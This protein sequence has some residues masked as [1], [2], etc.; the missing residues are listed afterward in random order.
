MRLRTLLIWLTVFSVQ[1][2][3]MENDCMLWEING[4]D[5][6]FSCKTSNFVTP[7]TL[8][9]NRGKEIAKCNFQQFNN[10]SIRSSQRE[11]SHTVSVE[12]QKKEVRFTI[13]EFRS[14]NVDGTWSCV[15]GNTKSQ[16]HVSKSKEIF[17]DTNVFMKGEIYTINHTKRVS[18][19][20]ST[21]RESRGK[22][23]E[24]LINKR[25]YVSIAFDPDKGKCTYKDRECH[26]DI[27]SCSSAGNVFN[28]TFSFD[29]ANTTT[30]SCD[31]QFEDKAT[32]MIFS[33]TANLLLKGKD[34]QVM[35]QDRR[36]N[37]PGNKV[38]DRDVISTTKRNL[39]TGNT[40]KHYYR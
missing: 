26:Q 21:C 29:P 3:S 31:I 19:Q 5:L 13:H 18:L 12:Y 23:A 25:S 17:Y 8:V 40:T 24:F 27:C 15:Q 11:N 4:N 36:I 38:F 33:I 32:S 1:E 16:S 14:K 9:N 2:L 30:Y 37:K 7:V 39:R 28:A 22:N 34:F 20:C 6:T 35:R 10:E